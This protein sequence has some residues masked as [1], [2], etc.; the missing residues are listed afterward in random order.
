MFSSPEQ[1]NSTSA[2]I[3]NN[4]GNAIG[5]NTGKATQ[6]QGSEAATLA[7]A[8]REVE[9]LREQLKMQ[10]AVIAAKDQTIAAL[11]G[12]PTPTP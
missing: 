2:H 1:S 3:A 7:L 9:F 5:T 10:D 8:H 4:S 12:R 11:L 6:Q